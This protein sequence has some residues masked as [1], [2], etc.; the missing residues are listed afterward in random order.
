MD[1]APSEQIA[2]D[3]QQTAL[4]AEAPVTEMQR[5][6]AWNPVTPGTRSNTFARRVFA[7]STVVDV[8]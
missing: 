2:T 7:S 1:E 3:L 5:S 8:A 4:H 6:E